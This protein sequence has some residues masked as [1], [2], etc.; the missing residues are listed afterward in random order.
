MDV[1]KR[2]IKDYQTLDIDKYLIYAA[3]E[4]VP[5]NVEQERI[6]NNVS[7]ETSIRLKQFAKKRRLPLQDVVELA[8]I[9][10][11]DKYDK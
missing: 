1:L 6:A 11:L 5:V 10:M 8:I 7:K 4:K 2:I 3:L 9:E